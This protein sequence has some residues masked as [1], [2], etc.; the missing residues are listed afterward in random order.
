MCLLPPLKTIEIIIDMNKI[1]SE[2]NFTLYK[3]S[4]SV[5]IIETPNKLQCNYG[6][7][8][9]IHA[10]SMFIKTVERGWCWVDKEY[11]TISYLDGEPTVN[12]YKKQIQSN[13]EEVFLKNHYI[14]KEQAIEATKHLIPLAEEKSNKIIEAYENLHKELNFESGFHYEGDSYRIYNE[15]QYIRFEIE[16]VKFTYTID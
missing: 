3:T 15:Y 13:K 12:K 14:S 6:R 2:E 11:Y 9:E 10:L 16:N 7:V 1:K 5:Y 4:N 8:S